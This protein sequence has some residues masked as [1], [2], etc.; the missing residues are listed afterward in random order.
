MVKI[1]TWGGIPLKFSV[2]SVLFQDNV[3]VEILIKEVESK[4]ETSKIKKDFQ[5]SFWGR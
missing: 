4:E 1:V 5:I 3:S 2:L